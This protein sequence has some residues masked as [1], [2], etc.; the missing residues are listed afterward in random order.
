MRFI[1]RTMELKRIR[2][3]LTMP[4]GTVLLY[5]KRRVGKTT[6][7]KEAIKPIDA[8]K[9][10]YTCMPIELSRNAEDLSAKA[11]EALGF[12]AM[13]FSNFPALFDFLKTRSERIIVILDEYQD[14]KKKKEDGEY[15]DALF[16]TIIDDL[17]E[18]I[19]ILLSGSA[20]RVMQ[21]LNKYD[22]PL[23]ERFR[24]EISLDEL[25]YIEASE[26]Y[27]DCPTRDKIIYYSV[28]G[29][30]PLLNERIDPSLGVN[31]NIIRLF[32][33]QNGTAYSYAKSVLDI[34]ASSFNDAFIILS[35]IGNGKMRYSEIETLLAS[36]STRKQLSRTLKTLVDSK[37]IRKRQPINSDS[38]KTA[39]YEISSN[40]LRFFLAYLLRR[41]GSLEASSSTY[42]EH[43]IE[44]S[45]D[46]FVSF[47]FESIAAEWFSI[48]SK[49]GKRNDILKIGSYWY[50]DAKSRKNGEFDV[51]LETK[52]GYEIY[53]CR[54]LEKPASTALVANEKNKACGIVGLNA[55]RFGMISSAGFEAPVDGVIEISGDDL[56]NM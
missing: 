46:T 9:I 25:T 37:L 39:F 3:A 26:F 14:L 45:L 48:L 2:V 5:G 15:V 19:S 1:G 17:G 47:R 24:E 7:I 23:Y 27:P 6:L 22:N 16:R 53:E 12:P 52:D 44:P 10:L 43:F 51:A 38:R 18:N 34:E 8:V 30:M 32:V 11:M 13:R 41:E 4:R 40:S 56:Y 50:N 21:E 20:I 36:E 35:R 28:F 33:D 31:E 49:T 55:S 29:G 42:F 54:F